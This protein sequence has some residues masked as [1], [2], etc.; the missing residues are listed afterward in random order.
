MIYLTFIDL[1]TNKK[2]EIFVYTR[3]MA[4]RFI[5]GSPRAKRVITGWRCDDPEDND[6]L[7]MRA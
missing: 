7:N 6:Y 1:K 2:H 4:L 3:S 5:K